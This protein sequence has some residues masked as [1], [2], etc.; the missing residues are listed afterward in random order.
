MLSQSIIDRIDRIT[1]DFKISFGQLNEEQLNF[2]PNSKIWS[3]SQNIDHLIIINESYYPIFEQIQEGKYSAPLHSKLGFAVNFFGRI[4]LQSVRPDRKHKIKTFP[5]W[6]PSISIVSDSLNHFIEHQ[7][8]LKNQIKNLEQYLGKKIAI[9]SPANKKIV[10]T[11]DKALD[12]ICTHE[13]RHLVQ[14]NELKEGY[15]S[16]QNR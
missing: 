5:I 3:I 15:L 9:H 16:K 7:E 13:E 4:I 10:Y 8:S 6:E 11:I 14:A 12:I 1:S 2:K